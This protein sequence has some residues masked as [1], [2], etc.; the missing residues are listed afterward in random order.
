[1]DLSADLSNLRNE[2]NIKNPTKRDLEKRYHLD[3]MNYVM[4]RHFKN[5]LHDQ[6][7]T[8]CGIIFNYMYESER[9]ILS[10]KNMVSLAKGIVKYVF[11]LLHLNFFKTEYFVKKK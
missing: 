1:M 3:H 10:F 11:G 4:P 8:E 2:H 7:F 9:G 6:G 5:I